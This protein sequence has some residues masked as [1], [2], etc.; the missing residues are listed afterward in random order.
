MCV[1]AIICRETQVWIF[2]QLIL[3]FSI[4]DSNHECVQIS[5]SKS[6][7][8]TSKRSLNSLSQLFFF[9][10]FLE[11]IDLNNWINNKSRE[12]NAEQKEFRKDN[13][14]FQLS[15]AYKWKQKNYADYICS[16]SILI[17]TR[18]YNIPKP[19]H[20]DLYTC[21][22]SLSH[23]YTHNSPHKNLADILKFPK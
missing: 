23:M 11:T 10:F 3:T 14:I 21:S 16:L 4:R 7:L 8:E 19:C 20:I 15:L 18:C 5:S 17:N 13:L 6:K 22:N 12:T 9:F 1:L 2:K